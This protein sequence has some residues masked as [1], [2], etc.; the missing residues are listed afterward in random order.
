MSTLS[1]HILN[2]TTGTPAPDVR[3][4]L[5]RVIAPPPA[6][7]TAVVGSGGGSAS[8]DSNSGRGAG[9]GSG[10]GAG[11][12][13][14]SGAGTGSGSGA[15]TGSGSGG[16]SASGGSL[17]PP[18]Q[19]DSGE[20][21][22][23]SPRPTLRAPLDAPLPSADT[24]ADL[25]AVGST[26]TRQFEVLASGRTDSDGRVAGFGE[27]VAGVYQLWFE[28]ARDGQE[29]FYPEVTVTFTI[30]EERHYHV[31]LLLSPFAF[32]TYRGS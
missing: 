16:S 28:V 13:S 19:L 1:T 20:T 24:T 15:G 21:A 11:A 18:G 29:S 8:G 9:T 4:L 12:G 2:T 26:V 7:D 23:T 5:T 22:I 32:S 27:L 3:V 25:S 31:P 14:G 10:R 30:T 17:V 6:A